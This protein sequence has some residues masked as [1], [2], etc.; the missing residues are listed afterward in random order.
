MNIFIPCVNVIF[1]YKYCHVCVCLYRIYIYTHIFIDCSFLCYPSLLS[2]DDL[3]WHEKKGNPLFIL[4]C[5]T[6]QTTACSDFFMS[7]SELDSPIMGNLA[8]PPKLPPQE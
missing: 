2:R 6:G 7:F 1:L 8:T 3:I 5:S 4:F